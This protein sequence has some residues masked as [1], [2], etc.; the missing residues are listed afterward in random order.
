MPGNTSIFAIRTTVGQERIVAEIIERRVKGSKDMDVKAILVPETLSGYVF[1]EAASL[2]D[3]VS[4]ISGIPHV[5]GQ[6][7]GKVKIEDIEQ[8]ITPKTRIDMIGAGDLVE[9][10]RGPFKGERAKIVRV[11]SSREEVVLELIESPNP[12]PIKVHADYVK[13]VERRE[14]KEEF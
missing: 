8:F 1:I 6:V 14:E 3:V 10:V 7:S 13:L 2:K 9:I 11:D 12:I 4:A 5:R